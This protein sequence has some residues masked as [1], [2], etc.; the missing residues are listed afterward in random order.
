[1]IKKILLKADY[2]LTQYPEQSIIKFSKVPDFS[3]SKPCQKYAH[4]L[5]FCRWAY[6]WC[7]LFISDFPV[8]QLRRAK[9]RTVPSV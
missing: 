7:K 5:T 8:K 1:M 4:E 6:I 3:V 9:S 2:F